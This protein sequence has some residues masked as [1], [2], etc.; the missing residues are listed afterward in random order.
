M[1]LRGT[2]KLAVYYGVSF[3]LK[4]C[5]KTASKCAIS[6]L[7]RKEMNVL[8]NHC[9][10]SLY[11]SSCSINCCCAFNYVC[12]WIEYVLSSLCHEWNKYSN[13][14]SHFWYQKDHYLVKV[15]SFIPNR[16]G[17]LWSSQFGLQLFPVVTIIQI[18]T[19]L[20]HNLIS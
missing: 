20:L 12:G 13:D 14:S 9:C 3:T 19:Q 7:W 8:W 4:Y 17:P 2:D 11:Q 15:G 1:S 5:R 18:I 16:E 6:L 10:K